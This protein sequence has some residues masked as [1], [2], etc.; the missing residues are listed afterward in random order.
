MYKFDE[1][2]SR[3]IALQKQMDELSILAVGDEAEKLLQEASE[4]LDK[5]QDLVSEA[6]EKAAE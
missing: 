1:L 2:S 5:V 3:I 4:L 6:R